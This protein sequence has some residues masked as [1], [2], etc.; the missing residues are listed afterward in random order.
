MAVTAAPVVTFIETIEA[1]TTIEEAAVDFVVDVEAFAA[2][3][4]AAVDGIVVV[5]AEDIGAEAEADTVGAADAIEYYH[6][7]Y[8]C[9]GLMT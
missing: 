7:Y 9:I 6:N 3:D 4:A 2:E 5:A 1:V 8:N